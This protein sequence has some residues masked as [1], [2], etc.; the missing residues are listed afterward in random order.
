VNWDLPSREI[1]RHEFH[2]AF[3]HKRKPPRKA[4]LFPTLPPEKLRDTFDEYV[5]FQDSV[6]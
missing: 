5:P 3:F 2:E 1:V 4:M 6:S